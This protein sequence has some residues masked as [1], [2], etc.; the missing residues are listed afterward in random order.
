[1]YNSNTQFSDFLAGELNKYAGV[2]VPVKA[3]ILERALVK[4]VPA[5]KLHPNPDDEFCM[6]SVGPSYSI[7]SD[8]QKKFA[9]NRRIKDYSWE[10]SIMVEKVRPDGYMILN[11]HH[12]WAAALRV[13]LKW[14]PV[15]IVNLPQESDIEK[16]VLA[17]T[18]DKRVTLDLDEVVLCSGEDVAAEKPPAF[19]YNL[20]YGHKVR[21]GIPALLHFL[22]KQGYDIWLYSAN[23]YSY[24]HIRECFKRY[25]VKIDG[26]ITGTARRTKDAGEAKKRTEQLFRNKYQETLH[27]DLTT[28]LRT[29]REEGRFEDYEIKENPGGWSA[30]VMRI[31]KGL[32]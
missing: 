23:Y 32:Q 31:V 25:T 13:G 14:L 29:F 24:D 30:E 3:G 6:P 12:R 22:A 2:M 16:M 28:V 10:D 11:G 5:R 4:N 27:I 8:Y 26:I 21:L 19:P 17:S 9:M 20:I 18:H 15:S 1:M 7:I